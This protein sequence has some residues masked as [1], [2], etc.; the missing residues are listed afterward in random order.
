METVVCNSDEMWCIKP[1]GPELIIG[2]YSPTKKDLEEWLHSIKFNGMSPEEFAKK[3][4]DFT[5]MLI[6][7]TCDCQKS[8]PR[9]ED[10]P[11]HSIQ[12]EHGN[13]FIK[14]GDDSDNL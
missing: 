11:L 3:H 14:I 9:L 10:V 1:L 12:C 2:L 8:F 4:D 13:W 5:F 6:K 7:L